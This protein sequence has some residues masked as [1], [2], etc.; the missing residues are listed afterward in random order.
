MQKVL[1]YLKKNL[2][3]QILPMVIVAII[4][5]MYFV[6]QHKDKQLKDIQAKYS[7]A[8]E[9]MISWK[10]SDSTTT[11]RL[12]TVTNDNYR[13]FLK[14]KSQDSTII[15]LQEEVKK[16]KKNIK[17]PGSSVT[18]IDNNTHINGS[19]DT[20]V[21]NPIKDTTAVAPIYETKP[22]I[23]DEWISLYIKAT[24]SKISYDLNVRNQYSV[25]IGQ[26]GKKNFAEVK[27]FNPYTET[28]SIRT[29]QVTVPKQKR[30][31]VGVQAGYGLG[32]GGATPYI[33]VGMSY[34]LFYIK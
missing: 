23:H 17:E 10:N 8:T 13:Q 34:N 15:K 9:E 22:P 6:I 14:I 11:A 4:A 24:S 30:L 2:V 18:V 19:T 31:G 32:A 20:H 21:T 33:G 28:T 7:L 27:N 26:E 5:I 12:Y 3:T 1:D 29:Y 16:H 25:V